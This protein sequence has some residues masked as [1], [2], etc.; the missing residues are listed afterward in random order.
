[1]T[2]SLQQI[3][4]LNSFD[5]SSTD[6]DN[7]SISDENAKYNIM[8]QRESSTCITTRDLEVC[9]LYKFIKGRK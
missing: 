2:A 5:R 9:A 7:I 4:R 8:F 6:Y 1:M 3:Q